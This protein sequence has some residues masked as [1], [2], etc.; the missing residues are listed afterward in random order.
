M[1]S[2]LK[3]TKLLK[4]K[5]QVTYLAPGVG[6]EMNPTPWKL[7]TARYYYVYTMLAKN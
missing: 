7:R 4:N 5:K 6:F 3:T 1:K 2:K